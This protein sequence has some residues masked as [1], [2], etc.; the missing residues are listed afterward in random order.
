MS[1]S[2]TEL[3]AQLMQFLA[4]LEDLP[5]LT[6]DDLHQALTAS[7]LPAHPVLERPTFL[8]IPC[9]AGTDLDPVESE[10]RALLDTRYG[11]ATMRDPHWPVGPADLRLHQRADGFTITL[12]LRNAV[13]RMR[14]AAERWLA[15]QELRPWLVENGISTEE[16][17]ADGA[18]PPQ[19][20]GVKVD[21]DRVFISQDLTTKNSAPGDT[22]RKDDDRFAAI[23]EYFTESLG[24]TEIAGWWHRGSRS[25]GIRRMKSYARDLEFHQERPGFVRHGTT[26]WELPSTPDPDPHDAAAL[27]MALRDQLGAPWERAVS[28]LL[29]AGHLSYTPPERDGDTVVVQ[30]AQ[31]RPVKLTVA[32]ER[33]TAGVIGVAGPTTSPETVDAALQEHLGPWDE[34]ERARTIWLRDGVEIGAWHSSYSNR[35]EPRAARVMLTGTA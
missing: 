27:L 10:A 24:Y 4:Q 11:K 8:R 12:M 13:A 18:P 22:S 32:E 14:L 20:R 35:L 17:L 29:A 5:H 26:V 3:P 33:V 21:G 31:G 23:L 30:D 1:P 9:P 7:E 25:F 19:H 34:R 28:A 15:G 16:I 2:E 6:D